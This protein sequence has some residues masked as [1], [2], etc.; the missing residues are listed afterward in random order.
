ME[1]KGVLTK[2][3]YTVGMGLGARP[4]A[5]ADRRLFTRT[6]TTLRG[7]LFPG[8]RDC[9]I[10]DFNR[11]GARVGLAVTAAD[12]DFSAAPLVVVIW[13]TG[14]AYDATPCWRASGQIGVKFTACAN[15]RGKVPPHLAEI[16]AQWLDRRRQLGRREL[17]RSEA[18][19]GRRIA[20]STVRLR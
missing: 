10:H 7:R 8:G 20:P 1:S 2:G 14:F 4:A 3:R 12:D 17:G 6:A 5:G 15:L 9:V 13:S 11:H 19:V 18:L 16:K